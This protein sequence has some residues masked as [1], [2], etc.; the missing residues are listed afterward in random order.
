MIN[1]EKERSP[2]QTILF[3]LLV[4]AA[5]FAAPRLLSGIS[6]N[7]LTDRLSTFA[8]V[9]LGIFIEAAPFLFVGAL[10]SGIVELYVDRDTLVRII[11]KNAFL[12]AL[13]GSLLGLF[14]PVCDCGTVPLTR[15]LLRKGFPIP[16]GIAFLLSAPI[17]NPI[18]IVSTAT[19]F[20]I[21]RMLFFRL[22]LSVIIAL[23]TGLVFSAAKTPWEILAPTDWI[24]GQDADPLTDEEALT[25]WGKAR[26]ILLITTDEFFDIGRF[27]IVG[28][29][30]AAAIQ[31]FVPQSELL[32]IGGGPLTSV[33]VMVSL[34][35]ILS[36]CS[37]VDAFV[38]LGFATTFSAGSILSFLTF[39]PMVDI[40][41][42]FMLLHVFRKRTVMYLVLIP[43]L[44]S[45]LAGL[46]INLYLGG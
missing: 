45:I 14:I 8:T 46:M 19:A 5:L 1:A 32:K 12:S 44:I 9:F 25:F 29:S 42:L 20:G 28:S 31:T 11:P 40:K 33:L 15:R 36:I 38:A 24:S 2:T 3:I 39:G 22:G 43:L 35:V 34:A 21:G 26:R 27:L 17:L 18:V 37:T 6:P 7:I 30:I 13:T 41:S 23:A 10:A 16:G 4:I